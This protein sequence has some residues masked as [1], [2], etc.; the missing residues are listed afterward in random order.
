MPV[1][2]TGQASG[3]S[4]RS[5]LLTRPIPM[6]WADS[7]TA[8]STPRS[9]TTV[10][11]TIGSSEYMTSATITGSVPR[12]SQPMNSPNRASDGIVRKTPATASTASR[13]RSRR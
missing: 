13:A 2:M 8:G 7:T 1:R 10:L 4:I 5:S 12:P 6:P 9:P 3:S 11:R